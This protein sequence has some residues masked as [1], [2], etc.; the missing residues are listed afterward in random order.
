MSKPTLPGTIDDRRYATAERT[1]R[2]TIVNSP[3]GRPLVRWLHA[4]L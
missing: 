1:R 4:N 3:W 2:G